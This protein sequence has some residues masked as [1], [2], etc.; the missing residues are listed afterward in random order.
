MVFFLCVVWVVDVV[1]VSD[2]CFEFEVFLEVMVY[3]FGEEFFLFVFV[4][5]LCWVGV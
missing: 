4:F 5:G 3:F 2:L 1:V